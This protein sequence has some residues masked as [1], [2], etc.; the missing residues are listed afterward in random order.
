MTKVAAAPMRARMSSF[1]EAALVY[2]NVSPLEITSTDPINV[3][4]QSIA[5][6]LSFPAAV[7]EQG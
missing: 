1:L 2:A 6:T 7:I 3:S 4:C 5:I